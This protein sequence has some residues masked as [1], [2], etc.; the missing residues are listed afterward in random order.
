M[1]QLIES[2]DSPKTQVS[3]EEETDEMR[4]ID[5]KIKECQNQIAKRTQQIR[6]V[7]HRRHQ[8]SCKLQEAL[9]MNHNVEGVYNKLHLKVSSVREEHNAIIT[10][11]TRLSDQLQRFMQINVLNDA[12]YIWFSGPFA[13]INGFR[14]GKLSNF[15]QVDWPGKYIKRIIKCPRV[16]VYEAREFTPPPILLSTAVSRDQCWSRPSSPGCIVDS[17]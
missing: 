12:F 4:L 9:S 1:N 8:L 15:P 5:A 6:E 3:V 17:Y 11:S 16:W 2:L 10:E 13:T 7:K 14:V